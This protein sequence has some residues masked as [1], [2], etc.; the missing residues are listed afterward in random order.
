[1]RRY[2]GG[3]VACSVLAFGSLAYGQ[4]YQAPSGESAGK[5]K[6]PMPFMAAMK[7]H[8]MT[9]V[10]SREGDNGQALRVAAGTAVGI[11]VYR[12]GGSP[13]DYT[14]KTDANGVAVVKGVPSNPMI[15]QM[16][17]YEA[18]VDLDGARH[19]FELNGI[20]SDGAEVELTVRRVVAGDTSQLSVGHEIDLTADEDSIVV[21]HVMRLTNHGATAVNLSALPGGGLSLSAP[22]GA[23]SLETH[24]NEKSIEVRGTA[25]VYRGIVNPGQQNTKRILFFYTIPYKSEVFQWSQSLPVKTMSA[26]VSAPQHKLRA[27]RVAIPMDFKVE[28]TVGSVDLVEQRGGMSWKVM[29]APDLNLAPQT[30]LRFKVTGVPVASSMPEYLLVSAIALVVLI[31]LFG[32]RRPGESEGLVLSLSHLETER[33][34]LL[35]VLERMRRAHDK[36]RMPGPRFEREKEVIMARLVSLYRAIDKHRAS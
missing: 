20:P 2:L 17:K 24:Q 11:R 28:K 14:A 35:K 16:L 31:I 13:K 30:P 36:G 33:D 6:G 19:P 15:Q 9:L 25:I 23:K 18:F 4:P 10:I 5:P 8:D 1:M 7:R 12:G 34:Q 21:R 27:Q 26:T 32:F 3:L 29:R 22:E